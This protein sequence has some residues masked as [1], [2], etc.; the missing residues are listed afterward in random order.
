MKANLR[1]RFSHSTFY[2][3]T[4]IL[5]ERDRKKIY[6]VALVQIVMGFVDLAGV[7]VI[8]I[9]GALAVNGIQSKGPGERVANV[10]ELLGLGDQTFQTQAAV[11]GILATILLL[12]RTI[13]SVFFTRKTLFF[14]SHKGAKASSE[15]I[16]KLLSQSL[17][18]IQSRTTQ[19]TLFAVTSGVSVIML[20]VVGT[21][22]TIIA[23]GSLLIILS[24]GLL[25]VDPTMALGTVL[26][27]GMIGFILYKIL[28]L[29]TK[30]LG[31]KNTEL[32]IES[33]EKILEVLNSYRES[34]VHNRRDHYA[35]EIG[36]MRYKLGNVLAENSFIPYISKYVIESALVFGGLLLSAVQFLLQDAAQAV[37]TLTVFMA[38]GSR[39]APAALRLQQAFLAIKGSLA[40]AKPTL[41]LMASLEGVELSSPSDQSPTI[42][43]LGFIPTIEVKDLYFKYPNSEFV[44]VDGQKFSITAGS[45]V[46]VVGSTGAGKTTA[47]DLILGLLEPENGSVLISGMKPQDAIV[48]WPGAISYVPQDVVIS[49]GTI[50]ENVGLGYKSEFVS[51]ELV[52]DAIKAAQLESY[53]NSLPLGSDTQVGERGTRM[54]G[55]QR[56]RLGIARALFTKPK[57]LV[58]DEATS[59]LDGETEAAISKAIQDLRG[60]VTV[61]MIAHRLSTVR[62]AD[63]IIYMNEGQIKSIGTFEEV[64][65]AVPDFDRQ[66][67]LMGL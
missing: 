55:G 49:N 48:R 63:S 25:I 45:S 43:H 24:I 34:M 44:A 32:S 36:S 52:W 2:L 11:L 5:S 27:F 33:N 61:I 37:A 57:L 59:A 56:Q 50:R 17:L 35:N 29:R 21:A 58:L 60:S 15:L 7:A 65:A 6:L 47:I 40:Q 46:A 30:V 54:S 1:H 51:E 64:R 4:R 20:G 9:L 62:N 22:V 26:M 18:E 10:L 3:S 38:A 39:I 41:E 19:Q 13:F 23:D 8:G 31:A 14:L 66:A 12:G 28:N 16:S 53:V 42:D 67:K